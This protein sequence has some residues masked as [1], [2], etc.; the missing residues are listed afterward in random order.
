MLRE[1]SASFHCHYQTIQ[2]YQ[3]SIE[4]SQALNI[5]LRFFDSIQIVGAIFDHYQSPI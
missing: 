2:Y 5:A 3:D 4:I 1:G